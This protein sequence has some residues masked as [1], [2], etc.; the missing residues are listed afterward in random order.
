MSAQ[1]SIEAAFRQLLMR[2]PYQQLTVS[3]VCKQAGVSRNTFYATFDDKEALIERLFD[4]HAFASIQSIGDLLERDHLIALRKTLLKR[5]YDNLFEEKEYYLA[6]VCP[7]HK[8]SD[9]TFLRVAGR[10]IYAYDKKMIEASG[11]SIPPWE[12][13]Y[14]ATYYS[15]SEAAVTQKW[16]S[17]GMIIP[18]KDISLLVSKMVLPFWEQLYT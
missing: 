12:A 9:T 2:K 14:I 1:E 13:E 11:R 7:L 3:E 15:S 8:S 5:Y 6:L 16:I 17:E 4:R 18:P 10:V